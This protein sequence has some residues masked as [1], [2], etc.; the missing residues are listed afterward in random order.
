MEFWNDFKTIM[1]KSEPSILF[2]AS[3]MLYQYHLL[4]YLE[5]KVMLYQLSEMLSIDLL[6]CL[7]KIK[8]KYFE[9]N[10]YGLKMFLR[11]YTPFNP[12]MKHWEE[13]SKYFS[14]CNLVIYCK[15]YIFRHQRYYQIAIAPN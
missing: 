2:N 12:L 5:R 9:I 6:V 4:S 7:L 1:I 13:L 11:N 8:T 14:F 10:R 3:I 15:E